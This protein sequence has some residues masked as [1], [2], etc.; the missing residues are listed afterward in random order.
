M[1]DIPTDFTGDAASIDATLRQISAAL[2]ERDVVPPHAAAP[3]LLGRDTIRLRVEPEMRAAVTRE[4]PSLVWRFAD[5][6][7]V[8]DRDRYR[9]G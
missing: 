6:T 8:V 3:A 4:G 7:V 9:A 2:Q 5:H 1:S